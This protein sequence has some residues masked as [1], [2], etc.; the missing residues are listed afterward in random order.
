[1]NQVSNNVKLVYCT[2]ALSTGVL[3]VLEQ[4]ITA[5]TDDG[6]NTVL[7]YLGRRETPSNEEVRKLFPNTTIKYL[8]KSNLSGLFRLGFFIIQLLLSKEN[9]VFHFHSSWAG[10]VGRLAAVFF[11]NSKTF[12][13]PH[14]F[15]FLRTD[16]SR[17]KQKVFWLIELI[18]TR[19]SST[20]L[21]AY[22]G[23]EYKI[24]KSLGKKVDVVSH[25]LSP[26]ALSRIQTKKDSSN[27][28]V[29]STLGRI[30]NAKNPSRFIDLSRTFHSS[31]DFI[32]IGDGEREKWQFNHSNVFITGWQDDD[33]VANYLEKSDIFVL[34]SDW[35]GL[36]F[37]VFD[38]AAQCIPVVIWNFPGAHDLIM[39]GTTG[40]VCSTITEL[41]TSIQSLIANR[42]LRSQ[43]GLAGN[44][45]F[46]QAHSYKKFK[47][48]LNRIY[49]GNE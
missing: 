1:M 35:E 40:Y 14:G 44:T 42:E 5:Q 18:L 9:F 21:L 45:S 43:I 22:G 49:F 10:F 7:V 27:R 38:A 29:I 30:A 28:L 16:I 19:I 47:E 32:W 2:E 15:A 31:A 8:G 20:V 25:Y 33:G 23:G 24:S 39:N 11:R 3:R 26:K 4:A 34:L 36:P 13:S 12:Y 46:S 6:V 17:S 37:S 48:E 41:E